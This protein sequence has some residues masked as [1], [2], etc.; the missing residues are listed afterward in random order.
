MLYI[1]Q[2]KIK[3]SYLTLQKDKVI[4]LKPLTVIVGEQGCGKSTLLK[5]L[6][7]NSDKIEVKLCEY[8]KNNYVDTFY[9]DTETMNPRISN[10][11]NYTTPGGGSKGIGVGAALYSHFQSHGE[12][13]REFTVNRINDAKNCILFLDEPESALSLKNQFLL[14]E[15]LIDTSQNNKTQIILAT[16]CLPIISSVEE[17][18][19]L[20]DYKWKKSIDFINEQKLF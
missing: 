6:K 3:E 19:D 9:F 17:V 4:E 10:L 13:L 20:V 1:E 14:S 16:H 2:I 7:N 11:D 15:R 8:L 18:F 5:L 12:V